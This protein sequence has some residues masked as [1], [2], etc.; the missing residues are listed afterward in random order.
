MSTSSL[1]ALLTLLTAEMFFVLVRNR[2][3]VII[4]KTKKQRNSREQDEVD[5][6]IARSILLEAFM[7]VPVSAGLALLTFPAL[8]THVAYLRAIPDQTLHA[9]L[10]IISYGF[11]FAAVRRA[12]VAVAFQALKNFAVEQ[13]KTQRT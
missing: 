11:P 8:M 1:N 4:A 13:E 6:G 5:R 7:F 2:E 12:V 3:I 10:G 9:S